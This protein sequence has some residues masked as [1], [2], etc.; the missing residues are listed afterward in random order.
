MLS[1]LPS[2]CRNMDL[3][4]VRSGDYQLHNNVFNLSA[5]MQMGLSAQGLCKSFHTAADVVQIG[6]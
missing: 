3:Q 1:Y 4:M 5:F 6:C 2:L